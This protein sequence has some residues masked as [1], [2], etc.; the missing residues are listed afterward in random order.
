MALSN[1]KDTN[2]KAGIADFQVRCVAAV[3]KY[4]LTTVAAEAVG[5]TN[6]ANR[7][8]FGKAVISSPA[9]YQANIAFAM[10]VALIGEST[11][12]IQGNN[13]ANTPADAV[14]DTYVANIYN[15]LAG[16]A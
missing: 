9:S 12:T 15:A 10:A 14:L 4:Y 2:D 11:T 6:H 7:V 16:V 1:Y 5:T 8:A 13:V 3:I